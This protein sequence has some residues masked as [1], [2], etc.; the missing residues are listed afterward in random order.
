MP[1]DESL[2][3]TVWDL[4]TEY[5]A[6]TQTGHEAALLTLFDLGQCIGALSYSICFSS[7]P[8]ER[9]MDSC[10]ATLFYKD[11]LAALEVCQ[12]QT[13]TL[14]VKEKAQYLVVGRWLI[15]SP[16]S[17]FIFT[18]SYSY[19]QHAALSVKYRPG[20][21]V[22]II[23]MK[24]GFELQ[25]PNVH[26]RSDWSS[27]AGMEPVQLDIRLPDPV[28]FLFNKLP[29]L[30]DLTQIQ[31]IDTARVKLI[32]DVQT[33]LIQVPELK[34]RHLDTLAQIAEPII[35]KMPTLPPTL[36]AKFSYTVSWTPYLC[37]GTAIFVLSTTIHCL[38]SYSLHR[39]LKFH[40]RFPFRMT[41]N[42]R[43][44]KAIPVTLVEDE[45]FEYLRTHPDHLIFKKSFL[46]TR[47][48]ITAKIDTLPP[49]FSL[50]T[51]NS[52]LYP[53]LNK[54]SPI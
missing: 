16:T 37:F 53:R 15:L 35:S 23:I 14:P 52:S 47:E 19:L 44:I 28:A 2:T 40:R 25:G 29:P 8:M 36:E 41:L 18:E 46:L 4:G 27:C 31:D 48:F 51:H 38:M 11:T 54:E 9:S 22:Y 12:I 45:D 30:D 1:P 3:A 34:R 50:N 10:L 33:K 6:V 5:L 49:T 39:I 13:I 32:T 20:C 26:L 17:D 42:K 43:S 7:F 24:C 21:K